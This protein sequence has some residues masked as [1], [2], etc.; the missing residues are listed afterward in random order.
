MKRS[1]LQAF[2]GFVASRAILLSL[3]AA[4]FA[5]T[6]ISVI[7]MSTSV[8]VA[9]T[10]QG[11]GS[12]INVA[13][14][15][16]RLTHRV[17]ALVVAEA[18]D[19]SIGSAEIDEAMRQF[20][21]SL[22]HP[23]LRNVI[24]REH[25]SVAAAIYRGVGANWYEHLKP[26]LVGLTE[27]SVVE[28]P[29]PLEY[30]EVLG[31]VDTFVEQINT[32]VLV[33]EHDA[34]ARIQQLRT[35][36]A[37]ALG[38]T[39]AV[40]LA[41]M[42]LLR[43]RVFRPLAALGDAAGRIARRDFSARSHHTGRDELGQVSE[44]FNSMASELS[45]A[46]QDLERRVQEKTADVVRSNRSLELLYHLITRLYHAP[47]SA[48]SYA[49]T[50][51]DIE[52]TLGLQGSFACVQ[53]KHG[54]PATI[55]YSNMSG[56]ARSGG[57]SDESCQNCPGKV[58]PWTYRR[59]KDADVLMVPL[60]DADNLYGMLRLS[61]PPGRRLLEWQ[62]TLL[63]A[64]SRH[65]GIALGISRQTERERL[66]ALQEERSIIAREL[67]DSLAQSLSYMKIQVSLLTPVVADP[68]RHEQALEVLNDLREGINS[69]YRQLRE[70]LSSFR[71][72]MEGDFATLLNTTVQEFSNRSGM[73]IDVDVRLGH[74]S[75][76]ANQ[77]I[78]LL[79]II[80][81]ALSNATRHSGGTRIAVALSTGPKDEVSLTVDD[82]GKGI[83]PVSAGSFN[84]YGLAIMGERARGLGGTL[85][86]YPRPGGGTR[87]CVRFNP[88][89]T[90]RVSLTHGVVNTI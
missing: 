1:L 33:L 71:L 39:G 40:V 79:H 63:E 19:G 58:A 18:L 22:V 37:V 81:E 30:E 9:E 66:I 13:G 65:M 72:K 10:V 85:E 75:L 68:E 23:S 2:R 83:D 44:A 8:V 48:E 69:A 32:L 4:F 67:H 80:R 73:P 54:G 88:E 28:E 6:L 76:G 53:A 7:G 38:L 70:L 24:G 14:S 61:M 64:V 16:R 87:V 34:E 89:K 90:Q 12:A 29:L 45:S 60:R 42:Y 46:Y 5:V 51:T 84:H 35:I 74:I 47:A 82:D 55:L 21:S 15:L 27:R 36:L 43:R 78:H 77:E 49:E 26:K 25:S 50:L 17:S 86:V 52:R 41:A 3:V 56:C 62:S 59:E 20:E 11:S 31:E 57:N